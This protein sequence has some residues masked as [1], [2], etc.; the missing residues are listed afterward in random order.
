MLFL[1]FSD[2]SYVLGKVEFSFCDV[3]LQSLCPEQTT[4]AWC[5]RCDK[6]QP[7][8]QSRQLKVLPDILAMNCGLDNQQVEIFISLIFS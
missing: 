5:D 8:L 3:L 2:I 1:I 7:T 4:P 6:Y